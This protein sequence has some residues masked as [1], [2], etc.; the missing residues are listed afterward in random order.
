MNRNYFL[1][2]SLVIAGF[3]FSF[4]IAKEQVKREA[5][6]KIEEC[7]TIL[8]DRDRLFCFDE[9]FNTP[10][11]TSENTGYPLKAETYP[12]EWLKIQEMEQKRPENIEG[13]WST[14]KQLE[15]YET[16]YLTQ[17]VEDLGIVTL[18]CINNI[19]R[20]EIMLDRP[21]QKGFVSV[22]VLGKNK[23]QHQWL[24]DDTGYILREGRG[25]PAIATMRNLMG[26]SQFTLTVND[27][28]Y[29]LSLKN[30][31]DQVKELQ[32]MCHWR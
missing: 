11:F 32:K 25:L 30:F 23:E 5:I 1:L 20:V 27:R 22:S 9:L 29:T 18:S 17:S 21:L 28:H 16:L 24:L 2:L 6:A 12:I 26:E 15:H 14:E 31:N 13:F 10:I 3:S 7:K 4:A 19:S 8:S